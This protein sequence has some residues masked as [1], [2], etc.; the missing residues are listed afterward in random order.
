VNND[1]KDDQKAQATRLM[2]YSEI[3]RP[4]HQAYQPVIL[5]TSRHSF[6]PSSRYR[7]ADT[8]QHKFMSANSSS[9]SLQRLHHIST[10]TTHR[11]SSSHS[12]EKNR[13]SCAFD[14]GRDFVGAVR[15][16]LE[17]VVASM[18]WRACLKR[19]GRE[20]DWLASV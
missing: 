12:S 5:P 7:Y 14:K 18:V 11:S 13:G 6:S 10:T 16:W 9:G 17:D 3:T 19:E 4:A 1:D 15:S 2:L 20:N 8:I